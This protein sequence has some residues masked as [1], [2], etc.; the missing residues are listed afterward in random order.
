MGAN[1]WQQLRPKIRTR[2]GASRPG[3]HCSCVPDLP[4]SPRMRCNEDFHRQ[5]P[6]K[7]VPCLRS[8]VASPPP[9]D[10][11]S[12]PYGGQQPFLCSAE[13]KRRGGRKSRKRVAFG[14]SPAG[15]AAIIRPAKNFHVW[16]DTLSVTSGHAAIPKTA[17]TVQKLWTTRLPCGSPRKSLTQS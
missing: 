3:P 8:L 9:R 12:Q 17:G 13:Q 14:L 1:P 7:R 11:D 15:S 2:P 4:L 16:L 10:G 5:R 6:P